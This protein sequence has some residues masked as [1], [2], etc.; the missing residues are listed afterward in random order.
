MWSRWMF[1]AVAAS[2]L[3]GL[4]GT[5][6][7]SGSRQGGRRVTIGGTEYAFL[8]VPQTLPAGPTT[9]SFENRGKKQHMMIIA[10]LRDGVSPDSVLRTPPASR[11]QLL[12]GGEGVLVAEPGEAAPDQ[13]VVPLAAGATYVLFCLVRDA[14]QQPAHMAL[15]MFAHF[16]AK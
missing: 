6:G 9:F 12:E 5:G 15:G 7:A 3:V 16:Q 11:R 2:G 4:L 1:R 14:P 10:R 8:G 13:L